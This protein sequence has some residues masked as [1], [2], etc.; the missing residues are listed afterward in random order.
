M[1]RLARRCT[2]QRYDSES[3]NWTDRGGGKG[4]PNWKWRQSLA[5]KKDCGV[6]VLG[7][8]GKK[9]LDFRVRRWRAP[10]DRSRGLAW[11]QGTLK[12]GNSSFAVLGE[13]KMGRGKREISDGKKTGFHSF[14]SLM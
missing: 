6:F 2:P 13:G 8:W 14:C 11:D 7:G 10:A 1:T 5:Q 3:K 4:R 9:R 12:D